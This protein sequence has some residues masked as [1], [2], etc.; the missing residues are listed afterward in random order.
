MSLTVVDTLLW[1]SN[2]VTLLV[3]LVKMSLAVAA[4]LVATKSNSYEAGAL[5]FSPIVFTWI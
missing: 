5:L 3:L 2:S 1:S 4:S